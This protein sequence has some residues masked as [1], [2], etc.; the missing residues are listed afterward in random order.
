MVSKTL[1]GL[2]CSIL[3]SGTVMAQSASQ[4]NQVDPSRQVTQ[5]SEAREARRDTPRPRPVRPV[6]TVPEL[7]GNVA[8]LALGLTLAVGAL[9]RE[10]RRSR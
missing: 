8:F 2:A 6:R 10:K 5:R 3:I 9:I 4:N 1:L 7:D